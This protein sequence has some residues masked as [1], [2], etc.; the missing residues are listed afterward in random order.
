MVRTTHNSASVDVQ[1]AGLVAQDVARDGALRQRLAGERDRLVRGL[2]RR[3]PA[4]PFF[5]C[6]IRLPL[7]GAGRMRRDT[8]HRRSATVVVIATASAAGLVVCAQRLS[9]QPLGLTTARLDRLGDVEALRE[10]AAVHPQQHVADLEASMVDGAGDAV[11]GAAA[12][13]RGEVAARPQDAAHRLPR[14]R[15]GGDAGLVPALTH[16]AQLVGRIGHRGV[17]MVRR[18]PRHHLAAIAEDQRVRPDR[19]DARAF[20]CHHAPS[21][22]MT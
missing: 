4:V 15:I 22:R 2:E 18:E 20:A 13:E 14:L 7:R 3:S 17:E 6:R 12:G 9:P 19:L 8:A 1:P 21:V 5:A 10:A 16:E 11:I